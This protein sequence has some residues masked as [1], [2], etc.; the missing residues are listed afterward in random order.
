MLFVVLFSFDLLFFIIIALSSTVCAF[1]RP[2]RRQNVQPS[3]PIFSFYD[4]KKKRVSNR[5]S[6]FYL[7]HTDPDYS[8]VYVT[9]KVND[10]TLIGNGMT[11]TCGR[12][13]EI[14]LMGVKALSSLVVGRRLQQDIFSRFGAFWR[15]LTSEPQLRWVQLDV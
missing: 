5:I 11:F 10:N 6:S 8:C 3:F 1:V 12:G 15:E 7:Q 4:R 13:T 2:H 9:I 14:V